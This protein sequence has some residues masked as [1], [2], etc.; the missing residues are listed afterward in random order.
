VC[1]CVYQAAAL[2]SLV[3]LPRQ[4]K[5]QKSVFDTKKSHFG[6][7][8]FDINP[9]QKKWD[10]PLSF[11]LSKKKSEEEKRAFLCARE[12]DIT[13]ARARPGWVRDVRE[14]K[15]GKKGERDFLRVFVFV[16]LSLRVFSRRENETK[17]KRSFFF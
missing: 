12:R 8:G 10:F 14:T 7:L 4:K 5:V 2:F 3:S 9:K 1:V 15:S 13:S 16:V 17:E 6:H 11:S